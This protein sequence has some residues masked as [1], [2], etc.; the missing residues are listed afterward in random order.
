M[1]D[2]IE[3]ADPIDNWLKADIELMH[4]PA[5]TYQRIHGRARRRR[6]IDRKSVV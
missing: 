6:T 2:P 3:P 4:P 1:T 5:G